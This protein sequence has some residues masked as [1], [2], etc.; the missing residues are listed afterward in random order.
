MRGVRQLAS[1][2][3]CE[4]QAA[5]LQYNSVLPYMIQLMA[6]NQ[7]LAE[8]TNQ[9][10]WAL[11]LDAE[12]WEAACPNRV[13]AAS[14]ALGRLIRFYI[15]VEDGERSVERDLCQFR[16]QKLQRRT[17]NM[18]FHDNAL[19]VKLNGPSTPAVLAE[20]T[21]DPRSRRRRSSE[22]APASGGKRSAL[23]VAMS[24]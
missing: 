15:S 16:E 8:T 12:C 20:G 14:R 9:Q 4:E 24:I 5:V 19:M 17:D 6:P 22:R 1:L 2:L 13:R 3:G 7:P 21:Q 11:L 23:A 10:A 18:E